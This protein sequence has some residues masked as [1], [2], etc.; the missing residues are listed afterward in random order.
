MSSPQFGQPLTE[1]DLS[2]FVGIDRKVIENARIR[3]VDNLTARQLTGQNGPHD[4]SGFAIPYYKPG[5]DDLL[6]YTAR[7]SNPPLTDLGKGGELKAA[8][9]YLWP[10]GRPNR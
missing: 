9:K 1:S 2:R 8:R 7:V 10:K 4:L 5:T 3:R 6:E